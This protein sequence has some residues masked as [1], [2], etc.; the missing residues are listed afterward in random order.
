MLRELEEE[1]AKLQR[2]NSY[3]TNAAVSNT[4][5]RVVVQQQQ[6][7]EPQYDSDR[8]Q[9]VL[10][11]AEDDD[12][13]EQS[14][15]PGSAPIPR[16]PAGKDTPYRVLLQ[17]EELFKRRRTYK[18]LVK[19]LKDG[20]SFAEVTRDNQSECISR[21]MEP[22]ASLP[23]EEELALKRQKNHEAVL[24]HQKMAD[25]DKSTVCHPVVPCKQRVGYRRKDEFSVNYGIDG[26][27]KTVGFFVGSPRRGLVCVPANDISI[28]SDRHKTV[29]AA[30]QDFLRSSALPVNLTIGNHDNDGGHWRTC[31][32]RTN[33]KGQAMV[34]VT[35]HPQLMTDE[36]IE[37]QKQK[38]SHYFSPNGPGAHAE[39]TSLFFQ[40]CRV[41]TGHSA[42][43]EHL[44][45]PPHIE[46]VVSGC[47]FLIGP[48]SF[49]QINVGNLTRLI[50]CV[51][52][53]LRL[54]SET[55]L[56]DLC[57]G[58]GLFGIVFS[59]LV[60]QVIGIE[61]SERALEE[62]RLNAQLNNVQ[63]S[64]YLAGRV[65][66]CIQEVL[67]DVGRRGH[68][69]AILNPG[70]GGVNFR[71]I[72]ELRA[73]RVSRL[74]YVSCQPEG[75]SM[76]NF[77]DLCKAVQGGV[78]AGKGQMRRPFRL[79]DAVPVDMFPGTHCCEHVFVFDRGTA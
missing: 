32:V 31:F 74:V 41:P 3:K 42:P 65:E 56:L 75:P 20:I 47:R 43:Y 49:F 44:F 22:F 40:R 78:M 24:L 26:N 8:H 36:Q 18:E 53:G 66:N 63:N 79:I 57:C 71:V 55:T 77:R 17:D 38:L 48:G 35:F 2:I 21:V 70:R 5:E 30:Y 72:E 13:A 50:D 61:A 59:P 62:A 67:Q 64:D 4:S 14:P 9:Q 60:Q 19:E 28:I 23:Y 51:R 39:V 11:E 7:Q 1:A 33:F 10:Q 6:Q 76:K 69:T 29:A 15:F 27:P 12:K 58:V 73:S 34:T 68:V 16:G 52:E 25:T 46:E 54:G 37:E 45:G